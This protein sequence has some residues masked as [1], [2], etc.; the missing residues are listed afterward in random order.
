MLVQNKY[1]APVYLRRC[2]KTV[3]L[4]IQLSKQLKSIFAIKDVVSEQCCV[5]NCIQKLS[6][7]C[8]CTLKS[9]NTD[10]CGGKKRYSVSM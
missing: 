2:C 7:L 3:D 6:L 8:K 10:C 4:V 1:A 9:S 5:F